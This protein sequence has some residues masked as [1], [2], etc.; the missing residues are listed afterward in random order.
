MYRI[1]VF[2][3]SSF[4]KDMTSP[5]E[6]SKKSFFRELSEDGWAIG[7]GGL[8]ISGIVV[9]A[10]SSAGF[11]FTIPVYQWANTDD[12]FSKVFSG[13]NLLLI[14]GIGLLFAILSSAAIWLSGGDVRKYTAGF[15]MIYIL[16]IISLIISGNKSIAYYGIE[17]VVFAL[18]AGLLLSNVFKLPAWLKEA[19][20]S[21]FF[22]KTGLVIL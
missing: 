22:I 21:E 19:A 12:L 10:L 7:I 18:V 20:R 5:G 15:V 17:Y 1:V 16:A 6:T 11:K 8:I 13:S 9:V 4:I 2:C 14:T 3:C